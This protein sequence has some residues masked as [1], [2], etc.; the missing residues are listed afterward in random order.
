MK[1]SIQ[2]LFN[3]FKLEIENNYDNRAV[4]GG[5]DRL[6]D[7]WESLA[8]TEQIPEDLIQVIDSN[9]RNYSRLSPGSRSDV[10]E[11]LWKRIQSETN[12]EQSPDLRKKQLPKDQLKAKPQPPK[13]RDSSHDHPSTE[14][15]VRLGESPE[16][17]GKPATPYEPLAALDS[18]VTVIQG[19]GSKHS[20][21]L[22]RL[23]ICTLRDFLF[24]TPRRYD[25]YSKLK[26]INRLDDG[27]EVTIIGT[28]EH[29]SQRKSK[30]SKTHLVE[31][32]ISDG[33]GA[34]RVTWFN[35]PWRTRRL[36]IG[37]QYA[38][39]GK[40]DKYL[41][42][43]TI[44][45][46]EPDAIDQQMLSS[47][48][49]VPVYPSTEHITQRWL[50]KIM[51]EVVSYWAPRIQDHLPVD[52]RKSAGLM[53][54]S[55]AIL[56]IHYPDSFEKLNQARYRLAFDEIFLLQIGVQQQRQSWQIK[57]AHTFKSS[58]SWVENFINR[59]PFILTS[60]QKRALEDIRNDLSK[61]QPMNRLLQGD[62]GSGKTIIAA[63]AVAMIAE[64]GSQVALMAPTSILAEQHY[65]NI[66]EFLCHIYQNSDKAQQDI[67]KNDTLSILQ[68]NE[69]KM[70]V[71]ATPETQ[72]SAIRDELSNG[73]IKLIIGTHALIE[74]NIE[75]KDLQ[76]II[77]DEQHRF[78]VQQRG[79]LRSK[80]F[81]PHLLV[82]TATPIPRSL[83]LTIYGPGPV[84]D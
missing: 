50:R 28:L 66:K 35:Q 33:T 42:R 68:E 10:L 53:E 55:T 82:M 63:I 34:L 67:V 21:T 74:E 40:I 1:S 9:L 17:S 56:Q 43:L 20:Q 62:V 36:Q 27:D 24:F 19:I 46:P 73:D 69:V 54:L 78:G 26:P 52:I 2:K 76:L 13:H 22:E 44:N 84:R 48:R 83:A 4:I 18:P 15:D 70:L 37:A 41:G 77:I 60:A 29:L 71:G 25:D 79:K 14:E 11:G 49:I 6:L 3:I 47:N 72:K 75:F 8:R 5:L 59:L 51:N 81:N 38:L 61:G 57:D 30:D 58:E 80:G 16:K 7:T 65:Q 32:I 12:N 31:A 45:N 64:H 23:G 39:A